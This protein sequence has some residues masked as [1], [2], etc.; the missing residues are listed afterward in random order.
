MDPDAGGR[1]A[2]PGPPRRAEPEPTPL[3]PCKGPF[4][5]RRRGQPTPLHVRKRRPRGLDEGHRRVEE[6]ADA[7]DRQHHVLHCLQ[8][9]L[10]RAGSSRARADRREDARWRHAVLQVHGLPGDGRLDARFSRRFRRKRSTG[11]MS[12]RGRSTSAFARTRGRRISWASSSTRSRTPRTSTCTIRRR[13]SG[14]A[15]PICTRATAAFVSK[16]RSASVD[17]SWVDVSRW[18]RGRSGDSG[19]GSATCARVCDLHHGAADIFWPGVHQ[20][21]IWLG[22]AG[23]SRSG[24]RSDAVGTRPEGLTLKR[25]GGVTI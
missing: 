19:A 25:P 16:T 23:S 2:R 5:A 14:S 3:D 11:R 10:E 15:M 24:P 9:V 17:G 8:S 22:S 12:R 18:R 4:R 13:R 21:R 7:D 20:G 1:N 6:T